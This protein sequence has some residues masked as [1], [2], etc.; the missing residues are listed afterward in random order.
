MNKNWEK[1]WEE[2]PRRRDAEAQA[3]LERYRAQL[4]VYATKLDVYAAQVD[5]YRTRLRAGDRHH[6]GSPDSS[7]VGPKCTEAGDPCSAVH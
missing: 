6:G 4:G 1:L 3:L 5:L 2:D 7:C